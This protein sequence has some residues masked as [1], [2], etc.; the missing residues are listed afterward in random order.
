[1]SPS[2][3]STVW[4][5]KRKGNLAPHMLG[6]VHMLNETNVHSWQVMHRLPCI[7]AY[8]WSGIWTVACQ[9]FNLC[10]WYHSYKVYWWFGHV[11]AVSVGS[12]IT[13]T[14]GMCCNSQLFSIFVR[15]INKIWA[16]MQVSFHNR[17]DVVGGA[18][19]GGTFAVCTCYIL[20]RKFIES[21]SGAVTQSKSSSTNNN[22]CA[23]EQRLLPPSIIV[24]EEFTMNNLE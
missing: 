22:R 14:I 20:S 13:V 11:S 18:M 3:S 12:P 15:I 24:K 19:L 16:K 21:Q 7:R 17:Y 23:G 8:S 5:E 6:A 2:F 10:S 9:K 4:C 1:M